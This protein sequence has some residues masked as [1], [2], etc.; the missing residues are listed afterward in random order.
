M[1]FTHFQWDRSSS[2]EKRK[3]HEEYYGKVFAYNN[4]PLIDKDLNI[5]GLPRQIWNCKCHIRPVINRSFFENSRKIQ[6]AKRN[7]FK[8]LGTQSK[9][10][11]N[12]IITLGDID[13][14]GKGK[15]FKSRFIQPGLC[16]IPGG[17]T[18]MFLLKR[19]H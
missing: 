8:K 2:K 14:S 10:V 15:R 5:T 4:P 1:G 12:A 13:D 16:G 11:H 9:T 3:L 19:K 6:N 18:G 7:I 17:N